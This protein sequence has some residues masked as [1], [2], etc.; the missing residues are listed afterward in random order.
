[1][2]VHKVDSSLN[3]HATSNSFKTHEKKAYSTKRR[4]G[5]IHS[6]SFNILLSGLDRIN[7]QKIHKDIWIEHT[8][9]QLHQ[10][11]VTSA[12]R[13]TDPWA[14][15][16]TNDIKIARGWSPC[17]GIFAKQP[18]CFCCIA[19]IENYSLKYWKSDRKLSGG[20]DE[21]PGP[22]LQ[23]GCHWVW[24][25]CLNLSRGKGLGGK[26]FRHGNN[27]HQATEIWE[28]I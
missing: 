15:P 4:N 24:R 21:L 19:T 13:N 8:I 1:M 5:K 17:K 18:Q 22:C 9:N 7:R 28:G 26:A 6:Y 3:V 16:Q 20:T 23:G 10:I 14:P 11:G 27:M 25:I 2:S 12:L